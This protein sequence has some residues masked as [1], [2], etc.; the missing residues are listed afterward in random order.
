MRKI[1]LLLGVLTIILALTCA[2]D[3]PDTSHFSTAFAVSEDIVAANL[4]PWVEMLSAARTTDITVSCEGYEEKELYPACHLTRDA[5]VQIVTN[6]FSTMGYAPRIEI[7]GEGPQAAHNVVAEWPGALHP[8]EVLLIAAHL[9][10]FYAAADD[11]GSAVAALLETARVVRKYSFARTI[12]FVAFDLEEF[13]SVGSTRYV[14]AGRCKDVVAAI[15]MDMIG[16]ATTKP[17]SQKD[18]FGVKLPDVGDFLVVA[19]NR[20]S[21]EMLQQMILLSHEYGLAK[22]VGV[23]TPGDGNYFLASPYTRSDHGMLWYHGIPA[24][25]LSDTANFRNPHYHKPTDTPDTLNPEFLANNTRALA[26]AVAL[27]A[28]VQL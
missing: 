24:L 13:G 3:A 7:F 25:F 17:N 26:A 6:A 10:G 18:V 2:P 4:M 22:L 20:D 21:A 8:E 9:D 12:R 28:E 5:A 1:T 14:E 15:I 19:G 27:F 16:Y 23:I 11:N